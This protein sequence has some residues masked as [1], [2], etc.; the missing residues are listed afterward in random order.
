GEEG[1]VRPPER[2]SGLDAILFVTIGAK[3]AGEE[4]MV[5]PPERRSGLDAI[6]SVTIGVEVA[7]E[8]GWNLG[9]T[10]CHNRCRG[11]WR[12]RYFRVV[13][14][15]VHDSSSRRRRTSISSRVYRRILGVWSSV[16][17][18]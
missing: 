12:S 15:Q 18:E 1:K 2:R 16:V 3:V 7:E 11:G 4:G 10:L 9:H 13:N 17:V 6:L 8:E 14:A 5:R